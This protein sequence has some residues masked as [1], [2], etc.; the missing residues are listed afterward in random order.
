MHKLEQLTTTVALAL[1]VLVGQAAAADAD[2]IGAASPSTASEGDVATAVDV[3]SADSAEADMA[4]DASSGSAAAG[5][6]AGAPASDTAASPGSG[7]LSKLQIHGFLTQAY[8]TASFVGNRIPL[9]GGSDP[10][11]T[12]DET[13]LGIPEDGTFDYRNLALQ[14]RY[15]MSPKDIMVIQFSSR[16][17]GF[18][19]IA[20]AEDEIELDWAFYDRRIGDYSS[21]KIGRVQ[22]PIGI[23]NQIRDVGTILPFY[24]P[25]FS[26]YREGSF[27]TETVDGLDF[28]HTFFAD[29]DWSLDL[30]LYAGSWE[31]FELTVFGEE[32]ATIAENEGYGFQLWLNTPSILRLGLGGHHRDVTEGAEGI[33]REPGATTRIDDWYASAEAIGNRFVARA[34]YREFDNDPEPAPAFAAR[35]FRALVILY[36][37]Q[38]GFNINEKVRIFGQFERSESELDASIFTETVKSTPREDLGFALNYLFRP[39]LVL[40]AEWHQVEGEEFGFIPVFGPAGFFLQPFIQE[41]SSG[42]YSILSLSVS[43]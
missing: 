1:L 32:E 15:E 38:L 35:D 23:F 19:P 2:P 26:F 37:V 27:T 41:F 11:P 39:S 20:D 14:F 21:I 43:F 8:A 30:D 28:S 24:R 34:E 42:D 36:Y 22:I 10:G 33:L 40:K 16:A 9:P 17:L 6:G 13:A 18:S 7:P 5:S 3:S 4:D 31:S 12:F 29:R 25:S